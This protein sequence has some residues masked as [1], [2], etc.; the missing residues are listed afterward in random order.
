MMQQHL[1]RPNFFITFLPHSLKPTLFLKIIKLTKSKDLYTFVL[2]VQVQILYLGSAN[3]LNSLVMQIKVVHCERKKL[4]VH[5]P[6]IN[7][8]ESHIKYIIFS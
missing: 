6:I 8:Y 2:K 1:K 7:K 5:L 4:C 3:N